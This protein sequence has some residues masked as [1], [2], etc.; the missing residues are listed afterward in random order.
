MKTL[1]VKISRD[2]FFCGSFVFNDFRKLAVQSTRSLHFQILTLFGIL[3]YLMKSMN[4]KRQ[5][6][7]FKLKLIIPAKILIMI[8]LLLVSELLESGEGNGTPLQYSCLEN[9]MDGGVW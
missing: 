9:P 3:S 5:I 1:C 8:S 4:E 2:I 6:T 7:I